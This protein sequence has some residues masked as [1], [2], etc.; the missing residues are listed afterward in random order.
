MIYL[1]S[2]DSIF[3]FLNVSSDAYLEERG[4]P[5]V[6]GRRVISFDRK[7]GF[8]PIKI[9][10]DEILILVPDRSAFMCLVKLRFILMLIVGL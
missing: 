1:S 4:F 3:L 5:K 10:S 7:E 9:Q 2:D 6:F 8:V